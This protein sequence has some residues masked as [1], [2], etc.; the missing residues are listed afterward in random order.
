MPG[1]RSFG[2]QRAVVQLFCFFEALEGQALG[3]EAA[4]RDEPDALA[5]LP[6]EACPFL[7]VKFCG[8]V[9]GV[10]GALFLIGFERG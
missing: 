4:H 1:F 5:K 8:H 7:L 2:S 6:I 9:Q 3:G 10:L